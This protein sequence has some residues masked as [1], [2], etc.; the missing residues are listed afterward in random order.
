MN[1]TTINVIGKE[2]PLERPCEIPPNEAI[3]QILDILCRNEQDTKLLLMVLMRAQ[4]LE[5][6]KLAR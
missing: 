5:R 1:E 6:I 4:S 3:Q 2:T